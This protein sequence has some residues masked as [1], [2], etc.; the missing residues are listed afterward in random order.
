MLKQISTLS[1]RNRSLTEDIRSATEDE[2]KALGSMSDS[3][4]DMLGLLKES[5]EGNNQ[6]V[7]L[8][9]SLDDNKNSILDSVESLSSLSQE[10]AAST[11]ETSA[12][13]SMINSNMEVVVEQAEALKMVADEL[14]DNVSMFT[15]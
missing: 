9:Q 15:I 8:V 2:G 13:L 1:E 14:R 10:N 3:F 4:T 5:E 6:I 11:E 12:A 7:E